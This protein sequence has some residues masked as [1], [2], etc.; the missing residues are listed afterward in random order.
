MKYRAAILILFGLLLVVT[1]VNARS[2]SKEIEEKC[3][4][5]ID[6]WDSGGRQL[7][8]IQEKIVKPCG[9]LVILFA[10][11]KERLSFITTNRNEFDFRVDVCVKASIHKIY[12][13]PEFQNPKIVEMLCTS[14]DQ[15]FQRLC[16]RAGLR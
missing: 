1:S 15:L 6:S 14:E 13:Q 2:I 8:E 9:E 11:N 12:P 7:S 5:I 3:F 10:T 4:S 16:D